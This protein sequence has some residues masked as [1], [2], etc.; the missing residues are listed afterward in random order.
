M[1]EP[2]FEP[3]CAGEPVD[4][5]AVDRR[6]FFTFAR[7]PRE[8]GLVAGGALSP[9]TVAYETFGHLSPDRRNAVLVVHA[10]TGDSHVTRGG[11]DDPVKGWWEG[12]VGHG[13][14]VDT[15]RYFVICSNVLGGCRGTTG[16]SSIDPVKGRPYGTDFPLVTIRD[17]V[18]VQQEL[19]RHLGVERL[20]T[21]IGGSMGGMQALVWALIYPE[22]V[23]SAISIA[24]PG[25]A[26]PQ[27]IAYN[28]VQRQAIMAD[29]CWQ[30][31]HYYDGP[32]PVRGLA[33]ARMLG[34]ITYNSNASMDRKFGRELVARDANGEGPQG[35]TPEGRHPFHIH[36]E[37]ENYLHY[38]GQKLVERYDANTYLYLTR[39]MDLF[40]LG[41]G[42][43][44][45]R[46]ALRRIKGKVLVVGIDSDILYPVYQQK[47]LVREMRA[48][49][50]EAYYRELSSPWGHDAF[51]IEIEQLGGIVREFLGAVEAGEGGLAAEVWGFRDGDLPRL[52]AGGGK[53]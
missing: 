36:F 46:H 2:E 45:V 32:G 7:P 43:P 19:I 13:K 37:I 41:A 14:P 26:S 6:Q 3:V 27:S 23:R 38:Q 39:A 20:V 33:I 30:G 9:V 52:R 10:L 4:G 44:S 47:E 40:E 34:M 8:F 42:F 28:E 18:R 51:L 12:M 53:T 21:V 17:M 24:A 48:S 1:K 16:P 11:E 5:D 49:G 31:G 25:R 35:F 22:L 29:P 50:V 15:N